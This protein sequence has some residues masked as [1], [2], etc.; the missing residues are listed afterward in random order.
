M[1]VRTEKGRSPHPIPHLYSLR[2]KP[3]PQGDGDKII[4]KREMATRL[5]WGSQKGRLIYLSHLM[6]K[7]RPPSLTSFPPSTH[8]HPTST[9]SLTSSKYFPAPR[10]LCQAWILISHLSSKFQI[11]FSLV[12]LRTG[13]LGWEE[14]VKKC[15]L[16]LRKRAQNPSW[17]LPLLPF[18]IV[19]PNLI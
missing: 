6:K 13:A 2:L 17:K 5:L 18:I 12:V 15:D 1:E 16:I 3:F 4:P 9:L 8:K 10:R 7:H 19:T 14:E 11:Q